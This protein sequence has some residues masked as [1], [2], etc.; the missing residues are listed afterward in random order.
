MDSE[1]ERGKKD[2]KKVMNNEE[3]Q[4]NKSPPPQME[5]KASEP[6]TGG[7]LLSSKSIERPNRAE[8]VT[9]IVC[10]S[11]LPIVRIV[12]ILVCSLFVLICW[13]TYFFAN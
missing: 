1:E 9:D 10:I 8:N 2:R 6:D 12:F 3:N 5:L 13:W 11:F 4:D 7:E